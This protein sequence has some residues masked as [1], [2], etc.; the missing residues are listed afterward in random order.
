MAMAVLRPAVIDFIEL[1]TQSE[2]LG[3]QMEEILVPMLSNLA[4]KSLVDSKI[5]SDLDIIIVAVKRRSGHMEFNPSAKT[6]I[7]EGDRLVAIGDR[8][9]LN[10][11]ERV[12]SEA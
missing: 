11:L 3:L 9:Q 2:S 1:A 12:I 8:S 6:I 4:G 7:E 10:I 5:R